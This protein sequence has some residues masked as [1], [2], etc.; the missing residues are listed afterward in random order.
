MFQDISSSYPPRKPAMGDLPVDKVNAQDIWMNRQNRVLDRL[1]TE[2]KLSDQ[3][4]KML[5]ELM[6]S[7]VHKEMEIE[8]EKS[9]LK[10]TIVAL[11]IT[12]TR[13]CNG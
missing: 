11:Q 8:K 12:Y 2:S 3:M 6:L 1:E 4:M 7:H 10:K 9:E 13:F 5:E